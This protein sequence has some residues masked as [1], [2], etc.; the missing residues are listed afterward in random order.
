MM[1]GVDG[2][3]YYNGHIGRDTPTR[4]GIID[5]SKTSTKRCN[6]VRANVSLRNHSIF[7]G[8]F[9]CILVINMS[10]YNVPNVVRVGGVESWGAWSWTQQF[11]LLF[12]EVFFL[13]CGWVFVMPLAG[14][15]RT[16]AP[17]EASPTNQ[18]DFSHGLVM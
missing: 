7:R 1:L 11:F 4:G 14:H 8:V 16:D 17:R 9:T 3:H 10:A 2:G 13:L 18:A 12:S 6:T 5:G 15:S